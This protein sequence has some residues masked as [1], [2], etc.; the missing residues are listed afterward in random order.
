M[1]RKKSILLTLVVM[2]TLISVMFLSGCFL[3][4]PTAPT[5][6][7]VSI[8]DNS[9]KLT[10]SESSSVD[11]F[12]LYRAQG[13]NFQVVASLSADKRSYTDSDLIPN[14]S[15]TYKILA[16]KMGVNSDWS[17]VIS[18]KTSYTIRGY[19]FDETNLPIP[20]VSI[21]ING[22]SEA[23]TDNNG[24]WQKSGVL[25]QIEVEPKKTGWIFSPTAT[26]VNTPKTLYFYGIQEPGIPF[27]P[28]PP[29][30]STNVST[31][32]TLQWNCTGS[33]PKYD[34]RFGT[35]F[36]PPLVASNIGVSSYTPTNLKYATTY[37]WKITARNSAG[38]SQGPLWSFTTQST[39]INV[40]GYVRDQNG[41]GIQN[42]KIEFSGGYQAVLTNQ[43][44]Y[45]HKE[46][47]HGVVTITPLKS[48][49][50]FTPSSTIVSKSK[51][52]VNFVG[53]YID[54]PPYAPYDPLPS[55]GAINVS[56][57]TSLSWNDSDPDGD[58]LTYNVYFGTT[59][60]PPLKASNI[61][62][63]SYSPGTLSPST[64]YYWKITA[65]DGIKSTSGPIWHF[66]TVNVTPS[67]TGTI[68]GKVDVYTGM[69]AFVSTA[70]QPTKIISIPN[71]P[72]LNGEK[73]VKGEVI[74]GFK[75][76]GKVQA[77]LST[78]H[79]PF[80][81]K[82]KR[83]LNTSDGRMNVALLK[84]S[85]DVFKAISHFKSLPNVKYA[86]PNYVVHA[87]NVPNDTYY[88]YQWNLPDIDVP[89]SWEVTKGANTVIVAVLDTG[90]SSNHPDLQ[91]ILVPGYNFISN[92][93]DTNDDY[94]HGTHVAGIIDADTN[95]SIG[96]AGVDW[97]QANSIKIMPIKVLDSTGSGNTYGIAQGIVYA[98]EHGA[99]VINMSLGGDYSQIEQQAC[100]YAYDNGV[101]IV[102]AA[103][104]EDLSSLD[105]PAAFSTVIPVSAVGPDNTRAY[106]S[107]YASNVIWAP[108]GDMSSSSSDGILSTYYATSTHTNEYAYMQ[109]TS[110]AAP[111]VAAI[112]ALMI[113]KG[114]TGPA[115]IWNVL[116]NTAQAIPASTAY[117]GYGLVNAYDAVTYNG[118][119]EPLMIWAENAYDSIVASTWA[120]DDGSY[121]LT[122]PAGTYKIYA[123]QDF[124]DDS[125]IDTG[126][127]YGY[128]GYN[129]NS[130]D[131]L[132][133]VA[134]TD[135]AS[136]YLHLYV[137]PKI[138]DSE[139]PI[140]QLSQKIIEYKLQIVKD[141]YESLKK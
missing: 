119:W 106:Y 72:H 118:G 89:Q 29:N 17:N 126:D 2:A 91:N 102:A 115:N 83:V 20:G 111:H 131:S 35:T 11:G 34:V 5:L 37:Y 138:N 79:F 84:V 130:S 98:T 82:V 122:L 59:S 71:V 96:V 58:F 42:V 1:K 133:S 21:L 112:V 47:L 51:N 66:K 97:G 127:F 28:T 27:N 65:S 109:G 74:V 113:S 121:S 12:K 68:N 45:W 69:S 132:Q 95:N 46:N 99:K 78:A 19:V 40:S 76:S 107:N 128:Y 18:V 24:Y 87:L 3:F 110:M 101:T 44:G 124:N 13:G 114:I 6:S 67:G 125:A 39:P 60:N 80:S 92:N 7:V 50:T 38:T 75:R 86:E 25:G 123:W 16:Y 103:G 53:T 139:N 36:D 108:G 116:K 57:N 56:T 15:Y 88:N 62:A 140:H 120:N 137:S 81:Y 136:L 31:N 105:Y 8:S 41:N 26:T 93:T 4:K 33:S 10:W 23:L 9:I 64:T 85:T 134:V 94:G 54:N 49:W 73:Y 129:G 77:L 22:Q 32:I 55:N 135:G 104:N 48:N 30:G 141:H 117:G 63:K 90:V 52:N 61:S 70:N 14:T 43:N 100:Q